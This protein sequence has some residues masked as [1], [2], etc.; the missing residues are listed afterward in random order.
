MQLETTEI[1]NGI[2]KLL[3]QT[4]GDRLAKDPKGRPYV[5][6]A[7]PS[8]NTNDKGLKPDHPFIT[9]YVQNTQTP[10]GWLLDKYIDE[11]DRTCYVVAMQVNVMVSCYG[12]DS[13]GIIT[14][15]KQ[16]LEF[17]DNRDLLEQLTGARL[18]DTGSM[19][20]NYDYLNTDH[21][22][23]TPLLISLALN[24]VI[25]DPTGGIIE[26][27]ILDGELKYS[28]LQTIP[29]ITLHIEAP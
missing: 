15:I 17:D 9:V 8:D 7:Y 24:S 10:Y 25:I 4:I 16:R 21:E 5:I 14:E 26:K 23:F 22:Q 27:V 2:V 13:H 28:E 20:N 19:P 12:K 18:L 1:E 11:L 3:V 6:V 29:E